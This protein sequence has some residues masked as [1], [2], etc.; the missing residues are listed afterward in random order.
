MQ[1]SEICN[2]GSGSNWTFGGHVECDASVM[3][4]DGAFGAVGAVS[5]TCKPH[6]RRVLQAAPTVVPHMLVQQPVP[7]WKALIIL[8]GAFLVLSKV[9]H[10]T[11]ALSGCLMRCDVCV[12]RYPKSSDCSR[13]A[14]VPEQASNAA[15]ARPAH[16]RA[17]LSPDTP[18]GGDKSRHNLDTRHWVTCAC[19][20]A[21]S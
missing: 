9:S 15:A 5:G 13:Q 3:S 2:A 8:A 19:A 11:A 7:V 6:V 10:L 4:G 20:C 16:V 1:D 12:R 17:A 18:V 14:S 21:G